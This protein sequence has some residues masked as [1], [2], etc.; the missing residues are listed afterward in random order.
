MC[1]SLSYLPPIILPPRW[2]KNANLT[3]PTRP[4][5]CSPARAASRMLLRLCCST[6]TAP[7]AGAGVAAPGKYLL[8]T[9]NRAAPPSCLAVMS[10]AHRTRGDG[11]HFSI[12]ASIISSLWPALSTALAADRMRANRLELYQHH[13]MTMARTASCLSR[14][15][16]RGSAHYNT[17]RTH[18]SIVVHHACPGAKGVAHCTPSSTSTRVS[19]GRVPIMPIRIHCMCMYG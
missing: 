8:T 12:M 13:V 9:T 5:P 15:N 2:V 18:Y 16:G 6:P 7:V 17:P 14:S 1:E 11:H 10:V 19:A 3:Y 4:A